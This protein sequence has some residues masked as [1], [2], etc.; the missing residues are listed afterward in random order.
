M[1]TLIHADVFFFITSIVTVVLGV[2]FAVALFY[3][4]LI[5]RD[6]RYL[7]DLARKGGDKLAL[8][9]DG[10]RDAAKAEGLKVKSI[11]DFF[12]ALFVRRAKRKMGADK[13]T[14]TE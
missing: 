7:S 8:D 9:M 4:V 2:L 14:G 6:L 13:K 3:I 10:L 1:A 5:L 11:F 12:L